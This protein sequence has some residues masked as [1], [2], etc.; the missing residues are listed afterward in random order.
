MNEAHGEIGMRIIALIGR[1]VHAFVCD[2]W[3]KDQEVWS[4]VKAL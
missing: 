2:H 4:R 1:R 3:K